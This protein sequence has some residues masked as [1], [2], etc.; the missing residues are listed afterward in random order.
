[1]KQFENTMQPAGWGILACL[2]DT[3]FPYRLDRLP[4]ADGLKEV[5]IETARDD[6]LTPEQLGWRFALGTLLIFGGYIAW[7]LIPVVIATDWA[8]SVKTAISAL[9]GATPFLTKVIAVALMGRPA[10]QFLKR[11]VFAR[12]KKRFRPRPAA[13]PEKPTVI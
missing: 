4:C 5:A 7:P 1:M 3:Q 13:E 11:T 6:A 9:F 10:Y 8:P 2:L 12:L